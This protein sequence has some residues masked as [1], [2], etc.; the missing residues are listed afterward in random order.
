M[1]LKRPPSRPCFNMNYLS[2]PRDTLFKIRRSHHGLIFIMR[3]HVLLRW[4]VYTET[5]SWT[6][7]WPLL[8]LINQYHIIWSSHYSP[9]KVRILDLIFWCPIIKLQ[10]LNNDDVLLRKYS[11][12]ELLCMYSI[13]SCVKQPGFNQDWDLIMGR[14]SFGRFIFSAVIFI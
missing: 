14:P 2:R 13:W 6:P 9:F 10:W 5:V 4:Y 7:W 11:R 12:Q 8:E 1:F 3:I